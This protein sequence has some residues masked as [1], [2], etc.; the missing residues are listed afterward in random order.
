[1]THSP[2]I[3]A[4]TWRRKSAP[5]EFR[6]TGAENQQKNT[7]P[8]GAGRLQPAGADRFDTQSRNRRRFSA[9]TFSVKMWSVCHWLDTTRNANPNP[10][11]N[12][13]TLTLIP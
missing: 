10:N 5:I 11:P 9:P 6:P 2:E 8:T 7:Q 4:E 1:M 12:T 13:K 3:G